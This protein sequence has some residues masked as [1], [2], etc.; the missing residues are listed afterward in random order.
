MHIGFKK[1]G[2]ECKKVYEITGYGG[3]VAC[4]GWRKGQKLYAKGCDVI[5]M[6]R[7]YIGDRFK[8]TSLGWNGLNNYAKFPDYPDDGGLRFK[9]HGGVIKPWK[10]DGDYILILGQVRGDASLKGQDISGWYKDI[11][12]KAKSLYGIP[13]YFRPHPESVK[14]GGYSRIDGI[15]N[16]E[17]SLN[18]AMS[19]ALLTIAYNSNS[20]LDSILAGVPCYAGDKGT[21]AWD[22]CMKSLD[23][24]YYPEREEVVHKI[25]WKQFTIDEIMDG[26]PLKRLLECQSQ[27]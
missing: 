25:A 18:E 27:S 20:C 16:I 13:V 24:L 10:K 11:A 6:E 26:W 14:K 7:G 21:M 12:E 22:L 17:G 9:L 5:V 4:W 23:E 8:Y 15:K 19:G 3:T 2:V 1:L